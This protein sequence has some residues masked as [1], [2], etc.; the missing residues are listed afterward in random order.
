MLGLQ[1]CCTGKPAG[2]GELIMSYLRV[3]HVDNTL[4]LFLKPNTEVGF[5]IV[6][7]GIVQV[8]AIQCFETAAP[9]KQKCTRTVVYVPLIHELITLG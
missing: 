2:T 5:F 8:E 3:G 1:F 4:S 7:R 9:E 6:S